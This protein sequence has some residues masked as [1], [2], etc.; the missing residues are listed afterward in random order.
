MDFFSPFTSG[1]ATS[2]NIASVGQDATAL[3]ATF[4]AGANTATT[5]FDGFTIITSAGTFSGS[6]SVYGYSV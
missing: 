6:V 3:L 2:I 1:R 4:R 5:S